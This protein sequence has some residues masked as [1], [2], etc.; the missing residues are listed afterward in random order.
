MTQSSKTHNGSGA[1]GVSGRIAAYFQRAQITPLLALMAFSRWVSRR[2][3]RS[4]KS[5]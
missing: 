2:V 5:T 1:L 4:R 3:R